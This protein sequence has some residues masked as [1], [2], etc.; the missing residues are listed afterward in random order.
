MLPA[1]PR[2][3]ATL[4]A[5]SS[6]A[7]DRSTAVTLPP[8]AALNQVLPG[9]PAGGP[10]PAPFIE[11]RGGRAHRRDAA[12]ARCRPAAERQRQPAGAT[13][14]FEDGGRRKIPGQALL[15]RFEKEGD[16]AFA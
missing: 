7:A 4:R 16:E 11:L 3:D 8:R 6:I 13:A 1:A 9:G 5:S 14:I 15:D 12:A 10:P 2:A